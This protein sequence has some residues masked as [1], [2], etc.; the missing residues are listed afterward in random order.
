MIRVCLTL[1][2]LI[3]L[4][5]NSSIQADSV[6]APF[7]GPLS[8]ALQAIRMTPADI[9]LRE[10]YVPADTFRLQ[11]VK[12][13]F[14][15]PVAHLDRLNQMAEQLNIAAADPDS[16][17]SL[18]AKLLDVA[19]SPPSAP[20][21]VN[22]SAFNDLSLILRNQLT[23][24]LAAA[25][26]TQSLS[27]AAFADLPPDDFAFMRDMAFD[28]FRHDP[29]A[30]AKTL[31]ESRRE[32]LAHIE[33]QKRFVSIA[34]RHDRQKILQAGYMLYQTQSTLRLL[35]DSLQA[36]QPKSVQR[37]ATPY[38]DIILGTTGSD[39]F[40]GEF[41]LAVDPGGND[42][43]QTPA[44]D[45]TVT[46]GH[47]QIIYDSAGDDTYHG[48][49]FC[50]GAGIFGVGLLI[51][52]VGNDIYA[53]QS[54][55]Q[56]SALFGVGLLLDQAGDDV[57]N[58][59]TAVQG[60]GAFGLGLLLDQAGSDSYHAQFLA[61]G[62]G[63]C[64]G[65][66]ALIDRDG[67]D[68]YTAQSAY[69]DALREVNHTETLAQGFGYGM[70]PYGSG[71]VGL[72]YDL[73]GNDLYFADVFGQGSCYWYALG[74]L[75]DNAGDDVYSGFDYCQGS[76]V[77]LGLGLCLDKAGNDSYRAWGVS[78]GCGHDLALG[79]LL[80]LTGEDNYVCRDLAQGGGNANGFSLFVDGA[81]SDGY[82]AKGGRTMGYSDTRRT[83][84]LAGVFL[85]LGGRDFYGT[86]NGEENGFWTQS[87]YGSGWDTD[88]SPPKL[89][90]Q[91]PPAPAYSEQLANDVPTL[92]LQA[93]AAQ[94]KYQPLVQPARN[95]LIGFGVD[96]LGYL[97]TRLGSEHPR[98]YNALRELLPKMGK[99]VIPILADSLNSANGRV[100][101][102]CIEYMGLVGDSSAAPYLSRFLT[103]ARWSV[104]ATTAEA[105]G[106]SRHPAFEE[107]L[108]PLLTDSV[109][110]VRQR[111]AWAIGQFGGTASIA[112]LVQAL[113]DT[114]QMVRHAA[115]NALAGLQAN[116]CD[117]VVAALPAARFP[118]KQHLLRLIGQLDRK[119]LAKYKLTKTALIRLR[120]KKLPDPIL[121]KLDDMKE[122]T[123][124]GLHEFNA[125]IQSTLGDSLAQRYQ[126]DILTE[127]ALKPTCLEKLT[128]YLTDTDWRTRAAA[129]ESLTFLGSAQARE[130]LEQAVKTE[131]HPRVKSALRAALTEI[132]RTLP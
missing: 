2:I 25:N 97:L 70:R 86:V 114:N 83:F 5:F 60:A 64:W 95:K 117:A 124:T 48:Q 90:N 15:Q 58:G 130:A 31:A 35:A 102:S 98:E 122:K 116:A 76:G 59:N 112:M 115:E 34:A 37:I 77:H 81:G 23:L 118:A 99:S 82:I 16:L 18:A 42:F 89:S 123:R 88:I 24:F 56:G 67:Y 105:L 21:T 57:Y 51:D 85:D 22:I 69:K 61:Q 30:E 44:Y 103:H 3:V 125:L 9:V 1:S 71:G 28:L 63:A 65:L 17:F 107:A 36:Q 127:A 45:S 78:Q 4:I 29:D 101:S 120:D 39:V 7:A 106:N 94:T 49:N 74:A 14:A 11:F 66:G 40:N 126:A 32:E 72:L 41:L 55:A 92:F 128:G 132:T 12:D 38:G 50:Q 100:V 27:R 91:K 109:A 119:H 108:Q 75:I 79:A 104:R 87:T 10:D 121:T 54:H 129:V 8:E 68:R 52:A 13:A 33:Q 96:S 73:N 19:W 131:E 43:Y 111:A 47:V 26:L 6:I 46:V 110:H 53:A 84:G 93:S 113:A 62:M 20:D 80:D